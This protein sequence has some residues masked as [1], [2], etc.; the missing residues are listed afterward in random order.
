MANEYERFRQIYHEQ[1]RPLVGDAMTGTEPTRPRP[2]PRWG[3]RD[4]M[5]MDVPRRLGPLLAAGQGQP[6]PTPLPHE[7]P[8]GQPPGSLPT[9]LRPIEPPI[10]P[11]RGRSIKGPRLPAS[12]S[13]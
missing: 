4:P 3:H 10:T 11:N 8:H 12:A 7:V 13:K 2:E 5:A 6:N 9:P 1:R